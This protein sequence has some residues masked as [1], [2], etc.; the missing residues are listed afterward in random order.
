MHPGHAFFCRLLTAKRIR[1]NF[2]SCNLYYKSL[3]CFHLFSNSTYIPY[4]FAHY[5][6]FSLSVGPSLVENHWLG[7]IPAAPL[8]R[9]Q[10][11]AHPAVMDSAVKVYKW[12][13]GETPRCN[14]PA[15]QKWK[16]VRFMPLSLFHSP[17][18]KYPGP[19]NQ[20]VSSGLNAATYQTYCVL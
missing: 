14:I 18:S 15:W 20:R 4:V 5:P 9:E 13:G 11:R 3:T 7:M 2:S 17:K 16:P 6:L 19:S 1:S 12:G 8:Y 10:P